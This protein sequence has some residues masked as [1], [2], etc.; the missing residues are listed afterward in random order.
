MIQCA[1]LYT[2]YLCACAGNTVDSW[3]TEASNARS[4]NPTFLTRS[5]YSAATAR[6]TPWLSVMIAL[7][8]L[9]VAKYT[10]SLVRSN[11]SCGFGFGMFLLIWLSFPVDCDWLVDSANGLVVNDEE[12]ALGVCGLDD[13]KDV[14]FC[15]GC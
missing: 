11:E 5:R 7:T 9:V 6:S 15:G 4:S 8:T 2:T 12:L 13:D 1:Y 14:V 10:A 3:S